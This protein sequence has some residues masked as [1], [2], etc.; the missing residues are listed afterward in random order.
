MST[1][2]DQSPDSQTMSTSTPAHQSSL[3]SPPISTSNN[4]G[5]DILLWKKKKVNASILAIATATWVLLDIYQYNFLNI[6]S[7]ITM[8]IVVVL[9]LGGNIMRLVGRQAPTVP[10]WEMSEQS[11]LVAGNTLRELLEEGLRWMLNVGAQSE[12]FEFAKVVGAL[13][14]F[15]WISSKLDFLTLSYIGV[16]GSLTVP[17][18]YVKYEDKIKGCRTRIRVQAKRWC[19]IVEEK[20]K[21]MKNKNSKLGVDNKEKKT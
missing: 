11:A 7:W 2:T 17:V 14:L 20:L 16:V 10:D 9:F 6:A 12:W 3:D 19:D 18:I 5:K 4:I 8:A 13:W 1:S 15:A 21:R